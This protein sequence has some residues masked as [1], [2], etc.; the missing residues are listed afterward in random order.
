MILILPQVLRSDQVVD[1]Q[2]QGRA[3]IS[4]VYQNWKNGSIAHSLRDATLCKIV[5]DFDSSAAAMV[6]LTILQHE[7]IVLLTATGVDSE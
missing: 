7:V 2:N 5:H 6:G 3:S 4:I 1:S